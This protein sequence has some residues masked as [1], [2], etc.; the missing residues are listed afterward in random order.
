MHTQ[1]EKIYNAIATH[2]G[3]TG[4]ELVKSCYVPKYTNRVSEINQRFGNPIE[5]KREGLYN[6][7]CYRLRE[8]FPKEYSEMLKKSKNKN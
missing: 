7:F 1:C 6:W 2:P 5:C 3:I 4:F 8:G